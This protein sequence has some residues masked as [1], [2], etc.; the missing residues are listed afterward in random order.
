MIGKPEYAAA[1][2]CFV[3]YG[4]P[5]LRLELKVDEVQRMLD[6][7]GLKRED[8]EPDCMRVVEQAYEYGRP[9]RG[10]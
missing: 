8:F 6:E 1:W 10:A 5:C 3:M 7:A 9:T 4:N 2:A